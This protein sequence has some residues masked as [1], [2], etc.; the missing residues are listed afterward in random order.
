MTTYTGKDL[1]RAFRTVRKNTIQVA[2]DIPADQWGF[3][4]TPD[5]MSI[6]EI[7]AHLAAGSTWPIKLHGRDKRTAVSFENFGTY[8]GEA[9]A[10]EKALDTPAAVLAA[11]ESEGEAFAS[12]LESMSDADLAEVV[13]FPAPIDPPTKTRFEMLMGVKEHEMHHRGQLMVYQRLVGVVP[14]LTRIRQENMA[15]LAAQASQQPN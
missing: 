4:P 8:I 10:F 14:H 5:C 2:T 13:S 6:H 7:L 9:K 3:R 15:R 11:L 12:F 1:G